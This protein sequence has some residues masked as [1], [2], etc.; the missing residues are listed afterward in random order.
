MFDT[1][2]EKIRIK[3]LKLLK[4]KGVIPYP[5]KFKVTYTIQ[6]IQTKAPELIAKKKSIQSAGRITAIRGH[7]KTIFVDLQDRYGKIQIYLQSKLLGD[8][9]EIFKLLDI[10]D[11][12]GVKGELFETHTKELTILVQDFTLLSKS[13]HPLP[14]KWHGL[15]DKEIRYRKRH[16]DLIMNPDVKNVFLTKVKLIKEIRNFLD[17]RG[18]I[19]V[20]TPILQPVYGGAF[21]EPFKSHYKALDR[22]FYL[23]ISDE[24]YLKKLIIGGLDKVYEFGKDFRNEGIDRLHNP[25]FT[26]LE[27]YQAYA[28]YEDIMQIVE[29]LF[30]N[31][32]TKITCPTVK[33]EGKNE[34]TYQGIKIKFKIPWQRTTF[35]DALKKYTGKDLKNSDISEITRIA[36]ENEILILK[37][38]HRGKIL[39][40]LFETLV[41]PNLIE[42]TFIIDYP[43]DISPLAK[44]KRGDPSLVERFELFV[45]GIELGNA[46][47]ELNDPLEQLERF[48]SQQE[49]RNKGDLDAQ[50]MDKDFI[51]A[52][53]FGMPP[54]GGLGL[55]IDRI[56]MLFTDSHSIRDVI[57]FP[58]LRT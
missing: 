32:L 25:E 50:I 14:E 27:L 19:E 46:F 20:D 36:E 56:V 33:R 44:E 48:K 21:A 29:Q 11:F 38:Y 31:L 9:Y 5:Y 24:L 51:E 18:F 42:P 45:A 4:E 23:R 26:Q 1:E 30:K 3:K 53:E 13:L 41:Q 55:G 12:I 39:N 15:Q 34:I 17:N 40:S 7:G 22:D 2:Q 28:D 43:K 8:K 37:G 57:L 16:L 6:D 47:S 10:G 54:T 49:F 58:Q 35:F 52:L